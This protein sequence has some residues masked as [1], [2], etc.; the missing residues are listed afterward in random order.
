[1]YTFRGIIVWCAL[2]F[3]GYNSRAS[4]MMPA[5]CAFQRRGG[6]R[7]QAETRGYSTPPGWRSSPRE[8]TLLFLDLLRN[9]N[10]W[11]ALAEIWITER[12]R[13]RTGVRI[14]FKAYQEWFQ[15]DILSFAEL[16]KIA[17]VTDE[18]FR[19]VYL[20][21]NFFKFFF[22]IIVHCYFRFKKNNIF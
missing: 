13:K 19:T 5:F 16:F 14:L 17:S 15:S 20:S 9:K 11:R 10:P 1:M 22:I 6:G 12:H 8:K 4:L 18:I 2:L 21:E 3:L 7:L